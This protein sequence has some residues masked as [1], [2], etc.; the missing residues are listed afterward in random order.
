MPLMACRQGAVE[1]YT[2]IEGPEAWY[3][4]QYKGRSDWINHLSEQH[5]AELDAAVSGVQAKG[6]IKI[7]AVTKADFLLPTLGPYLEA[8]RDEVVRGRGFALIRGVPVD[9]YSSREIAIAYWGMGLYWGK[10]SS[11]NKKGHLI[12]H[13]KDIGH[14]PTNPVTR[15]Y[16]TKAAQPFHNDSADIVGLLCLT[17]A[18]SGGL[19]SWSSSISVHNEIL[20]KAPHLVPVLAGPNWY[21]DRKGEV[22]PGKKPFFRIPVFNYYKGYLSVNYS[23]NYFLLSQRHAEVPRLTPEQ[24]DAM[25]LFNE[26][27]SSDELRL[28]YMLQPGEIQLLNNHTQLHARSE[29]VDY[30]DVDK[31]RHLLRL[32]I[33][34]P[35]ERPLPEEYEDIYGGPLEIGNRGGIKVEGTQE[36]IVLEAE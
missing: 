23:D 1:P 32:W 18:R 24:Y 16:A 11:N 19:S 5:I 35:N 17:N 7:Q 27:A 30:D 21:F 13:I 12:G 15:L 25:K 4:D 29:F 14:D 22:P 6:I 10:A 8:I 2:L 34:P 28:D 33:S 36:C 26:L 20:K 9:R 3:A 31:R